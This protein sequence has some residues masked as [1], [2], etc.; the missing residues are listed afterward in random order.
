MDQSAEEFDSASG[1]WTV[2]PEVADVPA[3]DLEE[4]PVP[5][6]PLVNASE[7][8][9]DAKADAK[10][11]P[12]NDPR[13]RVEAATAKEAEAKR[14]RDEAKAE[15][16]RLNARIAE[17]EAK[18]RPVAPPIAKQTTDAEPNP[19]DTTKYPDGQ[20]D[21]KFLKDQARWSVKQEIAQQ[22]TAARQQFEAHQREQTIRE[23]DEK[24]GARY[25]AVLA[26]DPD[27]PSKV[28]PRLLQTQRV[29]AMAD[30]SEATF[31][32]F[33]IEQVFHSERPDDLLLHLSDRAVVQRL[34]TLPP[35]QV[36]REL[37]RFESSLGAASP[38]GPVAKA[39]AISQA[40]PPIK[41]VGSSPLVSNDEPGEDASDDEWMRHHQAAELKR[42]R[43]G[44]S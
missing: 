12:R 10:G 41:P 17:L 36:I 18:G 3:S 37:A 15:A 14:E 32:N 43:A 9:A 39:P 27:F 22:Q 35:G 21:L 25:Q 26:K 42:R 23:V 1:Q 29:G 5:D 34:A 30:P 19:E 6:Q 33:L 8:K 7:A 16:T 31:G 2:I 40:K 4:T 11:K 44:R 13:A 28:D 24:F 38:A 20:F